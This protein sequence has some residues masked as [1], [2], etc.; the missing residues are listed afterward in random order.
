MLA[1]KQMLQRIL[2]A[3]EQVKAANT[4]ENLLKK[5]FKLYILCIGQKKLL[6]KFTA[7]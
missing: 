4:C 6:R 3:L 2:I 5:S 1:P 7:I